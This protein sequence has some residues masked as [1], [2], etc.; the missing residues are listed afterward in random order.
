MIALFVAQK[1]LDLLEV[2]RYGLDEIDQKIVVTVLEKYGGGPVGLFIAL[3]LGR[4]GVPVRVFDENPCLQDDPRAATTH[5]ATLEIMG[6]AGLAG[7]MERVGLVAPIFQ[8][9]DRPT[10]TLVAQFDNSA[11]RAIPFVYLTGIAS[12]KDLGAR[13]GHLG[14]RMAIS[15]HQ[16][17]EQLLRRIRELLG[18]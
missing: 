6:A 5:P 8:F 13:S 15:K 18:S 12:P 17:P 14:G 2:D 16:P 11:L 9:W 1:A 10:Q 4:R 3:L 7:D